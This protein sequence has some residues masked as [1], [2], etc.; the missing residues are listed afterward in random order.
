MEILRE[1]INCGASV[2][3]RNRNGRTPLFLA[4]RAGLRSHVELLRDTGAHLH[5]EEI[6]TA[7]LF[8]QAAEGADAEVW[9]LALS[10]LS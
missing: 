3:L 4:A 9:Q 8:E 2:H 6:G 10:G 1:F 7:K 5:S